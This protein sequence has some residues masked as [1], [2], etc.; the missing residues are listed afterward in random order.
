MNLL[1]FMN[2]TEANL[3]FVKGVMA[4][5][6]GGGLSIYEIIRNGSIILTG[7]GA[8]VAVLGGLY[9]F[10]AKQLDKRRAEVELEKAE[11]ELRL[12]RDG[13]ST[14]DQVSS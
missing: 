14:T 11:L 12:L 1:F 8:L 2:A 3:Q 4:T 7:I 5:I 13:N 10:R 6:F 9:A